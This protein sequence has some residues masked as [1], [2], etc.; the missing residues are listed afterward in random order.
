[1]H[2]SS[3]STLFD[4][5]SIIGN[6]CVYPLLFYV[7]MAAVKKVWDGRGTKR[8]A[9]QGGSRTGL[10]SSSSCLYSVSDLD[11]DEMFSVTNGGIGS[12]RA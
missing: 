11:V 3:A 12:L 9:S 6:T 1:M 10:S 2:N 5:I 7:K 8:V 4:L